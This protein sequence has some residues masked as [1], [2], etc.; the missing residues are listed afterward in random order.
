MAETI[1]RSSLGKRKSGDLV[2]LERAMA[3]DG[4]FGGHL[5][6]GHIDGTGTI[7]SFQKEENAVWVTIEAGNEIL[8]LVVEKGSI[9][10]D[11]ISLT[12]ASVGDG[13]FQVS[14]I[15]H[16]G[17]KTTLLGKRPGELV[18]LETD[19]IGKYVKR[20]LER[21]FGL[22]GTRSNEQESFKSQG[23]RITMKTLEEYGF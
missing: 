3:A 20:L 8:E 22:E 5:V 10:I 7:S 12:V 11:G 17:Q 18:N 16:T 21:G 23:G 6:S 4:R 13:W 9:C 1:R 19:L 15:P 14:L 2:N